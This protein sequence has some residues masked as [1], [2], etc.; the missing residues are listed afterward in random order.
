[1]RKNNSSVIRLFTY[2]PGMKAG[3]IIAVILV[4]LSTALSLVGPVLNG[5]VMDT[6]TANIKE[7][8]MVNLP[9]VVPVLIVILVMRICQFLTELAQR[10]IMVKATNRISHNLRYSLF[11]KLDRLPMSYFFNNSTGD[12]MSRVTNDVDIVNQ[13]LTQCTVNMVGSIVTIIAALIVML[14]FDPL[15]TGVCVGLNI[16]QIVIVSIVAVNS[17]RFYTHQVNYLGA[18]NGYIEENY[19]GHGIILAYN[20]AGKSEK[21][22]GDLNM[23]LNKAAFNAQAISGLTVPLASAFT[24]LSTMLLLLFGVTLS[25]DGS[26]TLGLVIT[27]IGLNNCLSAPLNSLIQSLQPL[28][29][30]KAALTRIFGMIDE[31]EL[32]KDGDRQLP[33][34]IKGS[35]SFDHVKFGYKRDHIVIKDFSEE[36]RP[37]QKVAIVGPTGAGKSTLINL[38]MRFYEVNSGT[39]S[40]DGIDITSVSRRSLRDRVSIVLQEP[41][42]FE[43]TIRENLTLGKEEYTDE[44][45][46][47]AVEAVGLDYLIS[48]L[49]GKYDT[50]LDEHMNLSTGQRQQLC[51][52]RA[53]LA[54]KPIV[55]LDEATSSIDTR[56][57]LAIQ[58]AMDKLMQGR[59]SFVIAHRLST[60]VNA[61]VILVL[62]DGDIVESG[63]HEELLEKK[64]MYYELYNSQF[65]D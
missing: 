43:D 28:V 57:E 37:G 65:D 56:T 24:Y 49:P 26:R 31:E 48:T 58:N 29:S 59:T 30:V 12:T 55:I 2:A 19:S 15:L 46:E 5:R 36:I 44:M 45:I 33:E 7:L 6:I 51:I 22:F 11:D 61:D 63:S 3:V 8:G 9:I 20:A 52:A 42:V 25:M 27:F 64:G 47:K 32:S 13:N 50:V 34:D 4:I 38:L 39:I 54:D 23:R 17:S 16:V 1:M 40:I 14:V 53:I 21:R 10:A 60:I 35:V 18:V 62:K 41:W